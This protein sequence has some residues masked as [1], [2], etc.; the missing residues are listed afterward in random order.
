MSGNPRK[1]SIIIPSGKTFFKDSVTLN[2][3]STVSVLFGILVSII[4]IA[5]GTNSL[6][7]FSERKLYF[8]SV[9]PTNKG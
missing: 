4:R 2:Q 1:S 3:K 7:C 8:P 6:S 9:F 5:I